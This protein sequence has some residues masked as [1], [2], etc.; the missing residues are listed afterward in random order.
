MSQKKFNRSTIEIRAN[1][2]GF[3]LLE[4]LITVAIMSVIMGSILTVFYEAH[5]SYRAQTEQAKRLQQ[6]RVVMDQITRAIRSA[7][8]D[9]MDTISTPP[10]ALLD[11]GSLQVTSD[12]TGS[13]PSTSANSKESTGDP[14]GTLNSIS[15]IVTFSYSSST[16]EVFVDVGYG[17][18]VAADHVTSVLFSLFDLEGNPTTD[19]AQAVRVKVFMTG[20]TAEPNMRTDMTDTV[21]LESDVFI[22]NR[23]PQ[24]MPES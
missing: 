2:Q 16:N 21:T 7:G 18:Q 4:A 23:T 5:A 12:L 3:S 6:M 13:E 14:D 20:E 19:P 10:V 24:I 8:N 11:D 15:E 1:Q 22:R 17:P 9:P